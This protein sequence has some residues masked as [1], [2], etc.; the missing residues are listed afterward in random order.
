MADIDSPNVSRAARPGDSVSPDLAINTTVYERSWEVNRFREGPRRELPII[1][2][3]REKFA[4]L[5]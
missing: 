2:R 4:H 1:P 5:R 3:S